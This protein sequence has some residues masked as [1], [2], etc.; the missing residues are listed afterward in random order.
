MT[1]GQ[2]IKQERKSL[3]L[4]QRELAEKTGISDAFICQIEKNNRDFS[5]KRLIKFAEVFGVTTDYLLGLILKQPS[6]YSQP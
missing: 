3:G 5:T 4:N 6:P 1:I 2:R